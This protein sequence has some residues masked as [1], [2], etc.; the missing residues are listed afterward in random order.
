[1]TELD[2]QVARLASRQHGAF[3]R[4]QLPAGATTGNALRRRVAAGHWE[5]VAPRVYVLCG[6]PDTW[7]RRL[8]VGLL[9]A[10]PDTVVSR[11]SGAALA[12]IPGFGPGPVDILKGEVHEERMRTC[13]LHVSSWI[14]P[15]HRTAIDGIPVTSVAR[16]LF[17]LAALGTPS[18][19]RRGL[20]YL[21]PDRAERAV[22]DAL[23]RDLTTLDELAE[24]V[25]TLGRQG[26]PG[27]TRMRAILDDRGTGHVATESALEDLFL[28]VVAASGLPLPSRQRALGGDHFIGR[29]DFLY[30]AERVAIECDSRRHHFGKVDAERDRWRDLEL[31]AAGWLVVRVTWWQLVHQPERFTAH[32]RRVLERRARAESEN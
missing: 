22:D 20:P 11:R 26:R 9:E 29:V 2:E 19:R 15:H 6:A 30:E 7:R 1:M 21:H 31:S 25:A 16:T 5:R 12:D 18:R 17:D 13:E 8:W 32:L 28:S 27:T 24:V 23:V 3:H 4:R 10:G 14:P